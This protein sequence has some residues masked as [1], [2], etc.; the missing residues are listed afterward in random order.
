[1]TYKQKL[2]SN[3]LDR[4]KIM[5]SCD[6]RNAKREEV[7]YYISFEVNKLL[8]YPLPNERVWSSLVI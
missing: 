6:G 4:S 5:T 8:N 1:M 2:L 3:T 7:Y